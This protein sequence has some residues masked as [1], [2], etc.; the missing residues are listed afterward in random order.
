MGKDLFQIGNERNI[1]QTMDLWAMLS[2]RLTRKEGDGS[3]SS[4]STCKND[5]GTVEEEVII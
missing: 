5:Q 1:Y 4:G 3:T 2:P